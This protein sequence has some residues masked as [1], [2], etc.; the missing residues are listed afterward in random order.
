M[1]R[2][3]DQPQD[4][5]QH[6]GFGEAGEGITLERRRS[7][8]ETIVAIGH[9]VSTIRDARTTQRPIPILVTDISLHGC[10]F[11]CES[12]ADPGSF[13]RIELAVGPLTLQSRLRVIR[14][15]ARYDGTHEVGAEFI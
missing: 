3:T 2:E 1:P 11:R 6:D 8:R 12:P 10:D 4:P 13:Y 15:R 9:L 5:F 7:H 14:T